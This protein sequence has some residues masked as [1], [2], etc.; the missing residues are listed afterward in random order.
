M[1]NVND[2]L[3]T[4]LVQRAH[5]GYWEKIVKIM[6][7]ENSYTFKNESGILTTLTSEKWITVAVYPFI[8]EEA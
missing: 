2:I 3:E 1:L 7:H 6:D 8:M 4:Q 5:D